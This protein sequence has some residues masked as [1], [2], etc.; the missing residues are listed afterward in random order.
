MPRLEVVMNKLPE[1][2]GC[3]R[4]PCTLLARRR[5]IAVKPPG[6][7]NLTQANRTQAGRI[8]PK[9]R[10]DIATMETR[11]PKCRYTRRE[12]GR[13]LIHLKRLTPRDC[14]SPSS[15]SGFPLWW[16]LPT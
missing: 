4:T 11:Q 6:Q 14:C 3:V 13:F 8:G 15:S 1:D 2:E 16:P 10:Y 7:A 12:A 5:L 9:T